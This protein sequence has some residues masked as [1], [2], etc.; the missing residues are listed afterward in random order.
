MIEQVLHYWYYVLPAFIIHWIVS[1]IHTNSLRRKL[2]AKPFTHTQLDGFYGF[3][4]GRDFLKAKRIGRQVDL[5]N[6]RFP[7]DIDTFSSYT[8]GNHVIFTRDPENI[9]ALLATQFNDFSLGG[10]IKFFKPLLGYGIFT[11]DGEGWK[12]SRAMLRPQFAREQLPMSPSLEPH[13]N[14]KAYPQEQRWV[15][16]IQELFFRF[17]VDSATEFLFGESVNSLKSASI[18]CDE[19][20]ELEERKKFAEAFNK[21]QEYISTRVALQQ[22]Y[23]FVN[24]SEFKECNE[25][26]HK[27]TNYYVQK[28][29]DATPEELEKQSGYVF[30]YEL[31]KQTRDPNVLR[32]HHSISLLAGRDTTAGLLSFAVFELARNPH[33]WAKLRE[34]VESQF[35]L[36]EES[37]I[38]EITFE[39][40]KRCEYLKAVMNET[41][42]LHPSV[43]RNAR[44]ALKDT[45]LPRGGGP[46]GKDPILVRKMSCSI[47]ISGTQIDPKHYGKDAKLFRPERWFESS[48]RNLGWAYLPFNGGPRICLGQQFALTEAGYILVRLA[49]SFDTLELKPDTEYLTKIS[50]LTMCL[51]GAFV[52]MD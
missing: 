19:E 30:L 45:T 9:K 47:F 15:F 11:L 22:L 36:G 40:L 21:A 46:D 49:Q 20:T 28:A 7:D 35:G 50:H 31:V 8:F 13:F 38:E 23:W 29:L 5:I 4:F 16:D 12:H 43:P 26:V 6:S 44:F 39:S 52:K 33:I 24:N 10:R 48:T 3:K 51:F 1:A 34:D 14:V 17:T 18:G 2:G 42:R 41:L 37:R 32:D 25:I 27:F